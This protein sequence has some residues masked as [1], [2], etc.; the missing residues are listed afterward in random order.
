MSNQN[1]PKT[2]EQKAKRKKIIWGAFWGT[3]IATAVAAGIGVPLAQANHSL[4]KP[5]PLL[6][7]S[8]SIL[9]I[10]GPDGQRLNLN[11]GDIN[12]IHEIANSSKHAA[13]GVEKQLIK[14]L[15]EKEYEGSLWYEAVY[16]A[17]KAE[18]DIKKLALKPIEE[19]KKEIT[20]EIQDLEKKYQ[21]QF[22][23]QKNW[24]EKFLQELATDRY[25]KAKSKEEAIEYLLAQKLNRYAFNRYTTEVNSDFTYSEL[26]NGIIANKDVYYTYQGKRV[27][28][29]KKGEKITLPFAIENKNYVLPKSD[30]K[31]L[32]IGTKD[33][34]KI[35]MF[36]T[37][38]FVKEYRNP[39]KFIKNWIERK[40]AITSNLNL[41]AH[42]D[43]KD[44][45]NPW[46]V[47]KAEI[48][49][50]LSFSAYLNESDDKVSIKQG[51]DAIS[52]FKGISSL[53]ET[54]EIT[55]KQEIAAKNDSNLLRY[56]STDSKS[57]DKYGFDGFKSVLNSLKEKDPN[58]YMNLLSIL[59]GNADKEK[60]IF[61]VEYKDDLFT[62][63]KENFKKIFGDATFIDHEKK[64]MKFADIFNEGTESVDKENFSEKYT[65]Y[66]AAIEKFINDLSEKDFNKSFGLA[67]R[68]AF[69][70]EASGYKVSTL[71]KSNGNY[72]QVN[73]SGILIQNVFS[74]DKEEVVTRLITND[75]SILSKANH[76]D[77]L[78]TKL[79]NLDSIFSEILTRDYMVN[80]LLQQDN[81]KNYIKSKEYLSLEGTKRKFNDQDILNAINYEKLIRE[82]SKYVLINGK[83]NEIK[84]FIIKKFNSN[85]YK[86]YVFKDNKFIL[87]PHEDKEILSY[88]F[89][90]IVNYINTK[91]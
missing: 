70:D 58:K 54:N 87:S 72:I 27:D 53:L 65:R 86:D 16:N 25:G 59:M 91:N 31:S 84:Q 34:V 11:Y 45:S 85:L 57:A 48:I 74:L 32:K 75:L 41:L 64:T 66:N 14:Y 69:S 3:A 56:V 71:I 5:S 47:T 80:D 4:P 55:K 78:N 1:Q 62:K 36:V 20:K 51:I 7:D 28:I 24:E 68:D 15:Y 63:L 81:F 60:S 42:P 50:L 43:P 18:K 37:K 17:D 12:K 73:E 46:V 40:Q 13:E 39:L 76:S 38:S 77:T 8:S 52:T 10:T 33:E 19:V 79:F 2:T 49:K 67:F 82:T 88:L 9:S 26:K 23:L 61:K 44:A 29:A 90:T 30:D 21:E 35:P 89:T 22:G 83:A 6:K